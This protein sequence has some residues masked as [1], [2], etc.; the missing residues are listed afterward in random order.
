MERLT[1]KEISKMTAGEIISGSPDAIAV[2]VAIDSRLLGKDSVFVALKGEQTDGHRF[3]K[4]AYDNGARIFIVSDR[5]L[6]YEYG[7]D[8]FE[9]GDATVIL[10]DDSLVALQ[11][12]SG[13][14]LRR[15]SMRCIA[16]TG[17]VGKTTTRDMLF[18]AISSRFTA[19]TNKKNYN[20]ET[21][22]PLTLLSFNKSMEVGVLEIGMDAKGQIERLVEITEPEAA[23]ITNIGISHIERLG[24][25]ENIF[26]AKMEVT[27][28]FDSSSTL[29]VNCD[30]DMLVKVFE[31]PAPYNVISVGT[32]EKKNP[33]YLVSNIVDRGIDG[34]TFSIKKKSG[35]FGLDEECN[36]VKLKIPGGHNAMNCALAVA[37]AAVMGVDMKDAISG[38][39][40]M[41]MTG[42]RLKVLESKE[43]EGIRIIDDAYNAAPTSMKS[44]L[45]T[46]SNTSAKRRVAVLGGVNELGKLS[47][48]EH[49]GIGEFAGSCDLDL[50]I[51]IGEMAAWIGEE[52][53]R[54]SPE[55]KCLHFDRKECIY[56]LIK[57]IF[58]PG[59]VVLIKASRG[60]ELDK[61]AEMI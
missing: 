43:V 61:L 48:A 24:S 20:S 28:K 56:P 13:E 44:A 21:G 45:A 9:S 53:A 5:D 18:A 35:V 36:A 10:T 22:L 11:E 15:M 51:T 8:V 27:S 17:S 31:R 4:S 38:I 3:I 33:D 57:E 32:D 14:Y 52:A 40:K 37:G 1:A 16:V 55:T 34:I 19:G 46:L 41:K 58:K 39:C 50:L 60:Y 42:S 6:A 7:K 26:E 49:R 25:R 54:K 12:L 30:D 23:I 29:V 2:D 59:D 47:E